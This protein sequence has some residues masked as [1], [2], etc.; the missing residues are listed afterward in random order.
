M[1]NHVKS[2]IASG[3]NIFITGSAGTGKSYILNQLR[4]EFPD[5]DITASTGMAA[6]NVSGTTIHSFAGIGIGDRP[7]E[8]LYWK[9]RTETRNRIRSCKMLAIDEISMLSAETLKLID[10]V[11]KLTRGNKLSFGGIQLIVIGDFLQLP[12]VARDAAGNEA[13]THFAFE[14][15]AWAA[16]NFE[17][18]LLEKVYRQTDQEFLAKLSDIRIGQYSDIKSYPTDDKAIRLFALNRLADAYNFEKLRA[19]KAPSRY[20]E[21]IDCGEGKAISMI[22]R[23]CLAPKDLYLKVGARV[24]FLINKEI[25]SGLIN[26]STGEVISIG[27]SD[28]Q[29]EVTVKFDNGVT[30]SFGPEIVARVIVDKE[31]VARRIQVPLRLAWAISIHKSQGMTL[32]KVHIN[33]EGIFECGQAYVAL[34]RVRTKEGLSVVNMQPEYVMANQKAVEFY[35]SLQEETCQD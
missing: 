19:I 24:M 13:E 25:E 17:T 34:S 32:D 30:M 26:G 12:P 35:K 3:R 7:A 29:G 28:S 10:E 14:S 1:I 5:M 22:Y 9:M 20:F 23:N 33:A 11:F 2:L 4:Q 21:A 8:D 16:A 15:R 31:E 18:V 6:I 27:S